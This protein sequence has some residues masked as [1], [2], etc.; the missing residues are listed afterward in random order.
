MN[1]DFMSITNSYNLG[2][3]ESKGYHSFRAR[4]EDRSGD[5]WW[6]S[7]SLADIESTAVLQRVKVLRVEPAW[8][9]VCPSAPM[10]DRPVVLTAISGD[11]YGGE[12][13]VFPGIGSPVVVTVDFGRYDKYNRQPGDDPL[14]DHADDLR[15][16]G[17]S[18]AGKLL[19][20]WLE[21]IR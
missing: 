14:E 18:D 11:S 1:N 20:E 2:Y 15:L 16:L 3:I 9:P 7:G 13:T 21:E 4:V 6:I 5:R 12:S 17:N 10:S 8:S 19:R